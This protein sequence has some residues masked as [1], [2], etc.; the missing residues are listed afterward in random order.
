MKISLAVLL[1]LLFTSVGFGQETSTDEF[2]DAIED[3]SFFI[4]EAYNQE[5][6][7]VQHIFTGV[8]FGEANRRYDYTF[9]QEWPIWGQEHQFSFTLPYTSLGQQYSDGI[10]DIMINYRYQLTPVRS[11]LVLAPRL[12][13][14]LP[15]GTSLTGISNGFLGGQVN[16]P[17]SKRLSNDFIIHA[18]AG[19]TVLQN[20]AVSM[21]WIGSFEVTKRTFVS[22]NIGGSLIWLATQNVNFMLEAVNN[23]NN[24]FEMYSTETETTNEFI[25][26]PAVR[27]AID[28]NTLQIV[29]GIG[30]P[31]RITDEGTDVG[32]F[33][34]LSFEHPYGAGS[35]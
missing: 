7:V 6:K 30:V 29:P 15:T 2:T 27:C 34:Y 18:N 32:V 22:Y 19:F 3:N 31:F 33:L 21:N 10:G 9:T 11:S 8:S 25:V 26:H 35:N 16:I 24:D 17:A 12:S 14:I 5:T 20:E 1:V 13:L 28:I 23:I 4:E